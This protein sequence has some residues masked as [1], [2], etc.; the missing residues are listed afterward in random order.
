[1]F[2]QHRMDD[3]ALNADSTPVNDTHFMEAA[4]DGLVQVLFHHNLDFPGLKRVKIDGVFDRN[5]VHSIQ[6]NR[7]VMKFYV[8]TYGCQMNV[9]DSSEI[10]RHL[11]ARGV[12]ETQDPDEASV[13]LVNTWTVRQ[14]DED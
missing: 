6:Y 12:V 7:Q 14:D 10:V 3:L 1:M 8:R 9:A 2:L 5:L 4:P 11:K 13:L